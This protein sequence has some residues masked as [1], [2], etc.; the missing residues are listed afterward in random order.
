MT[1]FSFPVDFE[2]IENVLG[3]SVSFFADST[4]ESK[5]VTIT[6]IEN[7]LAKRGATIFFFFSR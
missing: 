7:I 3:Q 2:F 1:L 6:A 4:E 5:K